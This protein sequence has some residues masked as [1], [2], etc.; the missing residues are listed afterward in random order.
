MFGEIL[1]WPRN[2][3]CE[4]FNPRLARLD[5]QRDFVFDE[6][7]LLTKEFTIGKAVYCWRRNS[8]SEGTFMIG[9]ESC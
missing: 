3:I 2:A 1:S 9:E 5:N 7:F 8:S 6:E 4:K